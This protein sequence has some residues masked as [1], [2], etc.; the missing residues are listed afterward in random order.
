MTVLNF[1]TMK[2][3]ERFFHQMTVNFTNLFMGQFETNILNDYNSKYNKLPG[4]RLGYIDD[5]FFHL[6]L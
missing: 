5:I 4:I 1:N 3:G 2:F 6:E